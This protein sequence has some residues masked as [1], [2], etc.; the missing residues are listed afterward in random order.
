[1]NEI[2]LIVI[3]C[4]LTVS[5][6]EHFQQQNREYRK[7]IEEA[8]DE[9]DIVYEEMRRNMESLERTRS[10]LHSNMQRI[11]SK[12][13]Q[14]PRMQMPQMQMPRRYIEAQSKPRYIEAP[15]NNKQLTRYE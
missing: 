9:M 6:V 12:S 8:E 14:M 2:I 11:Q 7:A 13:M 3:I 15:H 5:L 4:G 10:K 1:M